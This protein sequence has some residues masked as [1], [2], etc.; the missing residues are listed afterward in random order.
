MTEKQSDPEVTPDFDLDAWLDDAHLPEVLVRV[1]KR[2]DLAARLADLESRH[3]EAK[4]RVRRGDDD[5]L[6]GSGSQQSAMDLAEEIERT[7]DEMEGGW[8]AIRLRA[9]TPTEVDELREVAEDDRMVEQVARQM[10]P[11]SNA[12]TVRRL[13]DVV[14]AGQFLQISQAA[15]RVSFGEVLTPD[16]SASVLSTLAIGTRSES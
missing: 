12:A 9:L 16:F 14:G 4:R 8:L 15:N 7:R 1:N 10:V 5:R 3:D 13:G 11:P 6:V 2:G